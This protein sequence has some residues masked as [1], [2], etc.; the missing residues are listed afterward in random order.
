MRI[1]P[2]AAARSKTTCQVCLK[3]SDFQTPPAHDPASNRRAGIHLPGRRVFLLSMAFSIVTFLELFFG[4]VVSGTSP[5]PVN[6]G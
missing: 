1:K 5:F 3:S 6:S 2:A 4:A